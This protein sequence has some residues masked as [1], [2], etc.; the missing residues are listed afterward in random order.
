MLERRK[1]GIIYAAIIAKTAKSG[2][3][4]NEKAVGEYYESLKGNFVELCSKTAP[5]LTFTS[6]K[7]QH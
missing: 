1:Q 3:N 2:R 4:P 7:G 6:P 5:N